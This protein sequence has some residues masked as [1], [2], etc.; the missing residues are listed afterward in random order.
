MISIKPGEL[1]R[2]TSLDAAP[3][4]RPLFDN[5]F[6]AGTM[7]AE[8]LTKYKGSNA[9]V[10]GLAR[11]GV[12]V[13]APIAQAFEVPLS[14]LVVKKIPSPQNPELAVG[15][16]AFDNVVYKNP[17]QIRQTG[18]TKQYLDR[19]I[20]N[21]NNMAGEKTRL[22]NHEPYLEGKIAII[23]D[24]GAATGAT[25]RAGIGFAKQHQAS[26][27]I[28]V[29]PVAARPVVEKLERLV[30]RFVALDIPD[31]FSAVG[32]FYKDFTQVTDQDVIFQLNNA[33]QMASIR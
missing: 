27:I 32:Q 28:V 2:I 6:R 14:V 8:K 11:G 4:K 10:I 29:V 24:D 17:E 9:Q 7:L 18:A 19:Q 30:D 22:Y 25:L 26:G 23:V 3:K 21:L 1:S 31:D 16:V 5:R 15:A 13:A 33:S 12:I 20:K